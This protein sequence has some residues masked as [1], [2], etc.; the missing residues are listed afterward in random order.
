M[1]SHQETNKFSHHST[2]ARQEGK[3]TEQNREHS[4]EEVSLP[5]TGGGGVTVPGGVH[6]E[7]GAGVEDNSDFAETLTLQQYNRLPQGV[8]VYPKAAGDAAQ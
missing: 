2:E 5:V 8:Q 1:K 3:C 4:G 7:T 6:E